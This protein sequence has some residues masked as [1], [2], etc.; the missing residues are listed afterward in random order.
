M[1]SHRP[2]RVGGLLW[3]YPHPTWVP[4][5]AVCSMILPGRGLGDLQGS[6]PT[7]AILGLCGMRPGGETMALP[8]KQRRPRAWGPGAAGR[9]GAE[10]PL[11]P[12]GVAMMVVVMMICL[13]P[14][15]LSLSYFLPRVLR[16]SQ[17]FVKQHVSNSSC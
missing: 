9:P 7:L 8:Y 16:A 17:P 11:E 12:V 2:E 14:L 10:A 13:F 15:F 1:R 6:L 5:C 4:S 3:R